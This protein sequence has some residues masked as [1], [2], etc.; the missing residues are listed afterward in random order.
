MFAKLQV[1]IFLNSQTHHM[2]GDVFDFQS[3]MLGSPSNSRIF[4]GKG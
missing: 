2:N 3:L 4:L 1:L